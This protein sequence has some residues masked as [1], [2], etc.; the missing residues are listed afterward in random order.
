MK[1]SIIGHCGSGKT[2]LAKNISNK[3][4]IPRLEIDR[5]FFIHGG[6][7]SNNEGGENLIK[8]KIKTDTQMFLERNSA[9]VTDGVYLTSVQ[10]LLADK[11]DQIIVL[12]IPLFK[13][14]LN[15]LKRW[16]KNADRHSELSR[17]EDFLFIF[18]MIRRTRNSQ[19]KI[20][21]IMDTYSEKTLVLKNYREVE[22]YLKQ[23]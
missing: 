9:W 22:N 18:D 15:H 6:A 5:L 13:R 8:E 19:P 21:S 1:I 23:L 16:F 20:Q 12:E 4:D 17:W 7:T 2:T 3:L 14:M 10:P 11:A